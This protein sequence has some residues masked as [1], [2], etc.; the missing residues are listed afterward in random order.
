MKTWIAGLFTLG[1][2]LGFAGVSQGAMYHAEPIATERLVDSANQ[3]GIAQVA[4]S[5]E[6]AQYCAPR[7]HH[8]HHRHSYYG[9]PAGHRRQSYYGG[10]GGYGSYGPSYG[11]YYGPRGYYAPYGQGYYGSGV[12]LYIGF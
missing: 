1:M 4:P 11:G 12:S 3:L 10:F 2:S 8:H 6:L 7:H 9:P 5:F